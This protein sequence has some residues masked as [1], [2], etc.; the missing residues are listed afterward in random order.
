MLKAYRFTLTIP[1]W[2]TVSATGR[3]DP[4]VNGPNDPA[5]R[6]ARRSVIYG[7]QYPFTLPMSRT[8]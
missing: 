1:A 5:S 8:S 7:W 3:V 6:W 2:C 4:T